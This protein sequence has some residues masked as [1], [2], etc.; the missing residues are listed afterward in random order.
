M[1]GSVSIPDLRDY[2][3]MNAVEKLATED[4]AKLFT[5]LFDTGAPWIIQEAERKQEYDKKMINIAKGVDTYWLSKPLKTAFNHKHSL[6][7]NGGTDML[8]FGVDVQFN[9]Q[10]GVM[11]GSERNRYGVGFSLIIG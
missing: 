6:Y 8:R 3:L 7:L 5:V 4:A 2:N 10:D 9:N 1:V 11:K